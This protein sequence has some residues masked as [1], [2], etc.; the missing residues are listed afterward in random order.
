[1][2][3]PRYALSTAYNIIINVILVNDIGAAGLEHTKFIRAKS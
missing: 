3:L 1:M 2:F